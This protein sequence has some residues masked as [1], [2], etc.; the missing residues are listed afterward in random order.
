[1]DSVEA[2]YSNDHPF[3]NKFEFLWM[4]QRIPMIS[5]E[6]CALTYSCLGC[7]L[8]KLLSHRARSQPDCTRS[9]Q[10]PLL[11]NFAELLVVFVLKRVHFAILRGHFVAAAEIFEHS[12]NFN[13][14]IDLHTFLS[15]TYT[16]LVDFA[17]YWFTSRS[18]GSLRVDFFIKFPTR[19]TRK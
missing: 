13:T 4:Y 10:I 16:L 5:K 14:K 11:V 2:Q 15:T 12:K 6:V 7:Y 8:I 3:P 1:M 17:F 18:T 9:M 19:L